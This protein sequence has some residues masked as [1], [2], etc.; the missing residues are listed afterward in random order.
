[1][2]PLAGLAA[3]I[4]AFERAQEQLLR[5]HLGEYVV[6]HDAKLTETFATGDQPITAAV[7]R[8]GITPY[9]IRRVG[10]PREMRLP[11]SLALVQYRGHC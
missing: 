3:N 5:R 6:F 2:Q 8:F 9:L 11:A 10:T 7:E 1:M 4:E